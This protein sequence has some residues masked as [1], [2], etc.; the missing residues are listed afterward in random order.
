MN[1]ELIATFSSAS[2]T[3]LVMCPSIAEIED[4]RKY[5]AE[6]KSYISCKAKDI[7]STLPAKL[8]TGLNRITTLQ[9]Q[10]LFLKMQGLGNKKIAEEL[11]TT[12]GSVRVM[13]HRVRTC[14]FP[15]QREV[16]KSDFDECMAWILHRA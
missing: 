13:L 14:I 8:N 15:C 6:Q 4:C 12:E 7:L 2:K 3:A 16:P 5:I 9:R 1:E 11:S 10:A